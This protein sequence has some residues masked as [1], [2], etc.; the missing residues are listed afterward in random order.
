[1]TCGSR[2]TSVERIAGSFPA[3]ATLTAVGALAGG[4]LAALLPV[5]ATTL[6]AGRQKQR[7][8]AALTYIEKTLE[9]HK[10]ELAALTDEQYKFLNETVLTLL[11]TTDQ[12]KIDLLK[13]AVRNGLTDANIPSHDA[14]FL[15]RILRDISAQEVDFLLRN[16][17]TQRI[18]MS[19]TPM[20]EGR[21]ATLDIQ[22]LS[23]EGQIVSG[24]ITLG[25]V[26]TAEPTWDDSGLLKY[27]P[28]VAKLLSVLRTDA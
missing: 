21:E 13:H 5:L 26:A 11:H 7:I 16:F 10:A 28:M 8:E 2:P 24:L 19:E 15:S 9:A 17:G 22:P 4:P 25:L 12:R 18:W 27:S 6:A 1:M 3:Q 20:A 14:V 23:A